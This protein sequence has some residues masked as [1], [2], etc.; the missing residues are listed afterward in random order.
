MSLEFYDSSGKEIS[1]FTSATKPENGGSGAVRTEAGLNRFVWDMRYPSAY[2]ID[3]AT[4]LLGGSLQGPQAIP[5]E[6]KAQLRVGDESQ[7]QTFEI[8]KDPRLSITEPDFRKQLDLSLAVR[9]KVSETDDAI[10]EIRRVQKQIETATTKATT[11]AR[12]PTPGASLTT[13]LTQ[14]SSPCLSLDLLDLTIRR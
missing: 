7:A 11:G 12:C 6:Y 3:G 4:F 8:E 2:G 5:G 14:C 1:S 13:N 10:N 9:D